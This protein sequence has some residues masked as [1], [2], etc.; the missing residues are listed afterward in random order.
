MSWLFEDATAVI[1]LGLL[2]EILLLAV[3]LKTGRGAVLLPIVVVALIAAACLATE[4]L[5]VTQ[6]ERVEGV[7]DQMRLAVLA[8]D[9]RR[10]N[11]LIAPE[12]NTLRERSARF[13]DTLRVSQLKITD[14]PHILVNEFTVPP[15]ATVDL[16]VRVA[17][18]PKSGVAAHEQA[19]LRIDARLERGPEGCWRLV[20]A[21][22]SSPLGRWTPE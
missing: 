2:A 22:H 9:S 4:F 1:V 16:I 15:T 21:E 10:A 11:D 5:V 12:A 6:R 3:L 13:F 18:R 14:G 17:G 7:V 19:L 20:A 8:N